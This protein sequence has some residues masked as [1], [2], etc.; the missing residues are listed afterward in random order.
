MSQ[1]YAV[2]ADVVK[3]KRHH[4]RE[5]HR[6]VEWFTLR[7]DGGTAEHIFPPSDVTIGFDTGI[8]SLLLYID[9]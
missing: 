5:S 8:Q 3:I 6:F 9:R 1:V 2:H 7:D 4:Y